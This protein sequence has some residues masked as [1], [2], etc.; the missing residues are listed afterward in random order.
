MQAWLPLVF[1]QA[2]CERLLFQ[3]ETNGSV[4]FIVIEKAQD[5]C[6]DLNLCEQTKI[7]SISVSAR[8]GF[9]ILCGCGKV[10]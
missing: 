1:G 5:D 9:V 10:R 4:Q 6:P 2:S 8:I 7:Q 3:E